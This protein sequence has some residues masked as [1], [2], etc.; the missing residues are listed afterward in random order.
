MPKGVP[1]KGYREVRHPEL[2]RPHEKSPCI[3]SNGVH[4]KPGD[5]SKLIGVMLAIHEWGPVNIRNLEELEKRF[6]DTIMFC[7]ENDIRITNQLMYYAMGLDR[8][9]VYKWSQGVELPTPGHKDFVKKV[10]AFCACYREMLGANGK[11]NPATLIWWQKNYDGFTEMPD[12]PLE[13]QNPLGGTED[14][15]Q[16]EQR[17]INSLPND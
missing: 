11:L 5:N 12:Q 2:P 1:K 8:N 9:Y 16:L 15:A 13:D 17:I 10:K 7:G 14:K 4:T 6:W 3:G